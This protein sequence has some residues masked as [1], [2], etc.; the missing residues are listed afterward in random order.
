M[1]YIIFPFPVVANTL[2]QVVSS[3]YNMY[4]FSDT[5]ISWRDP[6]YSTELALSF[7]ETTGC[8]YIW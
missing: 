7:Q 1:N 2:C 8:S 6:E 3:G 4:L 5:I